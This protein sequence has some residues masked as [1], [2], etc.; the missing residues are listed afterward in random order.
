[1]AIQVLKGAVVTINSIDLSD[2][3]T[4]IEISTTLEEIETTSFA[5]AGGR[6]RIAGLEDSS[7]SFTFLQDFAAN[8]VD[9]TMWSIRGSSVPVVIKTNA[10]VSAANPQY[11]AN[12]LITEWMP[13]ANAIGDAP[14]ISVEWP[15]NGTVTKATA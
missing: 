12:V 6:H 10:T 14:E 8:E 7:I 5:S 13:I 9:A 1:M 11:S 4:N 15:V 3:I 2:H